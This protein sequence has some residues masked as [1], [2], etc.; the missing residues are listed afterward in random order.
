M[1]ETIGGVKNY[2]IAVKKHGDEI[3]FLRR[4]IRGGADDSFGIEV[5][6]LAGVPE[7]VIRRAKKI[8]KELE[9]EGAV[10]Q[11]KRVRAEAADEDNGQLTMV[12]AA[13]TEILEMLK[14]VDPNVLSPIEAMNMLFEL[15]KKAQT[16]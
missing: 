16:L 10:S 4:I 11:P 9:S 2:N 8:L 1:E 7:T 3:T 5:A 6:K 15:W 12:P 13:Q 14:T